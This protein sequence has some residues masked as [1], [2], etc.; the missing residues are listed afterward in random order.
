MIFQ[1]RSKSGFPFPGSAE[2]D[3]WLVAR[4][5]FPKFLRIAG[6]DLNAPL[7]LCREYHHMRRHGPPYRKIWW[8]RGKPVNRANA[9]HSGA[10]P[11]TVSSEW[12]RFFKSLMRR[13]I[14]KAGNNDDL[15]ARRPAATRKNV[16]GRGV[17]A[18]ASISVPAFCRRCRCSV[19]Q[20]SP[21]DCN[22]ASP[23]G[24]PMS[25][26]PNRKAAT[27]APFICSARIYRAHPT[28]NFRC[29]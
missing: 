13:R 20:R 23:R 6:I 11:A 29:R 14:G 10:A 5:V 2:V 8:L 7:T 1:V 9:R 15:R 17:P 12:S 19:P 18:V 3:D 4:T 25:L 22:N 16:H 26:S 24:L 28:L 21:P 27:P